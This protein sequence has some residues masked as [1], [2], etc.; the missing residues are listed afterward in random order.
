MEDELGQLGR[1]CNQM[2]TLGMH[3]FDW[4]GENVLAYVQWK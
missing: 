2:H 3:Q 4:P 1:I